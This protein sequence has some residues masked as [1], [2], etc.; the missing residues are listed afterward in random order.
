MVAPPQ[1]C[2]CT[3]TTATRAAPPSAPWCPNHNGAG[4]PYMVPV[5][6]MHRIAVRSTLATVEAWSTV[7]RHRDLLPGVDLGRQRGQPGAHQP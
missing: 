3:G 2:P 1:S 6:P 7:G 4:R 5:A